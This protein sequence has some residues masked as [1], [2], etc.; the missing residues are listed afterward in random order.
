[1]PELT[2]SAGFELAHPLARDP[3]L[4][5]DLLERPPVR[6]I[7]PVAQDDHALEPRLELRDGTTVPIPTT[8]PATVVAQWRDKLAPWPS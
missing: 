4:D 5:T 6:P 3:E 1:M 8:V 2:E 7:E